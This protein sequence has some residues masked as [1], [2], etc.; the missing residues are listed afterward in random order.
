MNLAVAQLILG[1]RKIAYAI[2]DRDLKV[3]EAGGAAGILWD[4]DEMAEH[5]SNLGRS[6]LELV[7]ELIGSEAVLADILAGKLPRFELAW[8]NR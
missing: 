4:S 1:D 8:V 7:P 3:V 2:T 5:E 6:L